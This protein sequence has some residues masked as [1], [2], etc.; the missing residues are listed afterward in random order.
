MD[1]HFLAMMQDLYGFDSSIPML[2]IIDWATD[3]IDAIWKITQQLGEIQEQ[4]ETMNPG[5]TNPASDGMRHMLDHL[6]ERL[7]QPAKLDMP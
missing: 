2:Q 7:R 5:L 3:N 4:L 1:E 6:V